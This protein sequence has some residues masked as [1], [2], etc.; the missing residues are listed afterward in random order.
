MVERVKRPVGL[1]RKRPLALSEPQANKERVQTH[2]IQ[3]TANEQAQ[4]HYSAVS[5]ALLAHHF[6]GYARLIPL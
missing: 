4:Y 6:V 3:E 5:V 2:L 1:S